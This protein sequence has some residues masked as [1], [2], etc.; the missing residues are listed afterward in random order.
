M[1]VRRYSW[2][3]HTGDVILLLTLRHPPGLEDTESV[4]DARQSLSSIGI[5]DFAF[6]GVGCSATA[7]ANID[8]LR[9]AAF[10]KIDNRGFGRIGSV[11]VVSPRIVAGDRSD[12]GHSARLLPGAYLVLAGGQ[13]V[14]AV[15][16]AIIGLIHLIIPAGEDLLPCGRASLVNR[17]Q[18]DAF[19]DHGPPISVRHPPR[20][21]AA[22]RNFEINSLDRFAR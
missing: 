4:L 8:V 13:P 22:A 5:D 11:G 12:H 20:N 14:N 21:D 3:C 17:E 7:Q 2:R 16:A 19:F 18:S 6:D 1:F 9:F 15:H 10:A